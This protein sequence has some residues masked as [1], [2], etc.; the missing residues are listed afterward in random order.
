MKKSSG[1]VPLAAKIDR[2]R[3]RDRLREAL[4]PRAAVADVVLGR[5]QVG[6]VG[7]LPPRVVIVKLRILLVIGH[8]HHASELVLRV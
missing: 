5:R 2:V 1:I 3:A 8:H 4:D 7:M 6:R